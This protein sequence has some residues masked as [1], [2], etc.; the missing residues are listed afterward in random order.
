MPSYVDLIVVIDDCSADGTADIVEKYREDRQDRIVL[1]QHESNQG[2][3]IATGYKFMRDEQVDATTV[4]AGD[5]Q[6]ILR[7][8]PHCLIQ[9]SMGVVITQRAID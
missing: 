7:I 2:E 8:C 4:M 3:R 6:I 1:I 5:G 9:L